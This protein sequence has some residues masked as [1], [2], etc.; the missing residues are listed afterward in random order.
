MTRADVAAVLAAVL[1]APDTIG[2]QWDL[3]NG[4]L[5]IEEAIHRQDHSSSASEE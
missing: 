1:D 5:P 2:R 3:V 4:D